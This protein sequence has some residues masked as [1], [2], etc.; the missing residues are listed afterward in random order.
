MEKEYADQPDGRYAIQDKN[1]YLCIS[2]G[3]PLE[4]FFYKLV[5]G[6]IGL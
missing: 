3:E 6:V 5:A 2:L 4:R 1:I